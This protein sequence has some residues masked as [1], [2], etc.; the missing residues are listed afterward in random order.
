MKLLRTITL[1][2]AS[3]LITSSTLATSYTWNGTT[4]SAWGIN[5][6]W[7]PNG[8][9]GASDNV[10]IVSSSNDPVYDG[11][12]GVYNLTVTSGTLDLDG[13]TL[14]VS[15]AGTF[16]GGTVTNGTILASSATSFLFEGTLMDC[17]VKGI[18]SGLRMENTVFNDSLVLEKNGSANNSSDGL[19]EFMGP[20]ILLNSG[21]GYL[22]MGAA[23]P[24]TFNS[25]VHLTSANSYISIAQNVG[26]TLFGDNV[27]VKCKTG[28]GV[29][30]GSSATSGITLASGVT[31]TPDT[32]STGL[33]RLWGIGQDDATAQSISLTGDAEL[34]L[35]Y[36]N[37]TGAITASAPTVGLRENIFNGI[38]NFSK[39]GS[40]H[41]G[42][43]GGN[44]F[45]EEAL[46]TNDGSGEFRFQTNAPDTFYD[47]T[48]FTANS[49]RIRLGYGVFSD[50][51]LFADTL[52]FNT[53]AN[54]ANNISRRS[55]TRLEGHVILSRTDGTIDFGIDNG[56]TVLANGSQVI[57][58]SIY[59][60][61]LDIKHVLQ[62]GNTSQAI[63]LA[64]GGI[65]DIDSCRFNGNVVFE[66][67]RITL[68][69]TEF[70]GDAYLEKNSSSNDLAEGG[71][72]FGGTTT[73][74]NSGSGDLTLAN[75][76]GDD[77]NSDVTFVQSS[78]GRIYPGY[79]STSTF[80]GNI[81]ANGI[82]TDLQFG[83]GG[84]TSL[85]VFDGTGV[86]VLSGQATELTFTKLETNKPGGHTT[87]DMVLGISDTLFLTDGTFEVEDGFKAV[88]LKDD[89]V[90][91]GGSD[92]SYVDGIAAKIGDDA[93]VFPVGTDGHIRPIEMSAPAAVVDTF[94]ADYINENPDN[95]YS[96]ASKD[97]SLNRISTN[98][99]WLLDRVSGSSTVNV[100]LNWS[101]MSCEFDTLDNLRITAWNGSQWKDLGNGGTTGT[102]ASGTIVTNGVSTVYGAYTLATVDTFRC[103][104][105][106]ADAGP[107]TFLYYT[108]NIYI[109]A[110]DN[111][112]LT[113]LWTPSDG[114]SDDEISNPLCSADTTTVYTLSTTNS[115]GCVANDQVNVI[116]SYGE[117]WENLLSSMTANYYDV[118]KMAEA[119]AAKYPDVIEDENEEGEGSGWNYFNRWKTYWRSRV[120]DGTAGNSGSFYNSV[121]AMQGIFNEDLCTGTNPS[122][123]EEVGDLAHDF[124]LQN[125]QRV[126]I[127]MHVYDDPDD[128]ENTFY[129]GTRSSG[130]WRT[131][132][133]GAN[134]EC[135]TETAM[136]PSFGVL[137]IEIIPG[138]PRKIYVATGTAFHRISQ[139]IG[140]IMSDDE[141]STWE[142]TALTF[143]PSSNPYFPSEAFFTNIEFNPN[144]S[145]LM[146]A[147]GSDKIFR[148]TDGFAT[149]ANTSEVLDVTDDF[150][151]NYIGTSEEAGGLFW[152]LETGYCPGSPC[153]VYA[154]TRTKS[155][156]AY[157]GPFLLRSSDFGATWTELT[158]F[159]DSNGQPV[160]A[161][162]NIEVA[163][164]PTNPN[165]VFCVIRAGLRIYLFK[166][167]D[168]GTTWFEPRPGLNLFSSDGGAGFYR[169]ELLV[170]KLS[171][172]ILYFSGHHTRKIDLTS[173]NPVV[174]FYS[175]HIDIRSLCRVDNS[176]SSDDILIGCDG[177]VSRVTGS[178]TSST[179]SVSNIN[180]EGFNISEFMGIQNLENVGTNGSETLD[181]YFVGGGKWDNGY[182][183]MREGEWEHTI[184]GDGLNCIQDQENPQFGLGAT[185]V[186]LRL[187]W[188]NSAF[189][190]SSQFSWPNF[191]NPQWEATGDG[192]AYTGLSGGVYKID[193]EQTDG[194]QAGDFVSLNTGVA[195]LSNMTIYALHVVDDQN[196]IAA[197]DVYSPE[198]PNTVE[199]EYCRNLWQTRDGGTSWDEIY[200]D[201]PSGADWLPIEAI[202]TPPNNPN[203]MWISF[204]G[205]R[206]TGF[207]ETDG[208]FRVVKGEYIDDEWVWEDYSDGL[209][210]VPVHDIIYQKGT[211]D[212]L[213]AATEIGVF[214]RDATMEEWKCYSNNLPTCMVTDLEINYCTQE[215]RAGTYGRGLRA[216][217][218]AWTS[219]VDQVISQNETWDRFVGLYGD[220]IIESGV[221]L[222]ITSRVN[223]P[224]GHKIVVEE[225]A[226]LIL[227]GGHLTNTCGEM[228]DGI[229]V[230]GVPGDDQG[231]YMS[232][233]QGMVEMKNGA[234][235]ENAHTGI[236]VATGEGETHKTGGIVDAENSSFR[237][238]RKDVA[239]MAYD[240][241][242]N[243][244]SRFRNCTFINDSPLNAPEYN[245][246]GTNG[247]VSIWGVRGVDFQSCEFVCN[248]DDDDWD[249]DKAYHNWD[250]DGI[251]YNF[252]VDKRG[253]GMGCVD[254]KVL[255]GTTN[256]TNPP[257]A[258]SGC[259]FIGLTIGTAHVST[260]VG[261]GLPNLI[262]N[263]LFSNNQ[264]SVLIEGG[265]GDR[266]IDCDFE[267]P[268]HH[269]WALP[270][271]PHPVGVHLWNSAGFDVKDNDFYAYDGEELAPYSWGTVVRVD[272][273]IY[274]LGI[275]LVGGKIRYNDFD[276]IWS[277]S[278]TE[279]VNISL[280]MSCNNYL[281][282]NEYDWL[283]QP[284]PSTAY[285]HLGNQGT[286]CDPSNQVRAGNSFE[287]NT[288]TNIWS[289]DDNSWIYFSSDQAGY[290]PSIN[291]NNDYVITCTTGD[292][293]SHSCPGPNVTQTPN[294]VRSL[295]IDAENEWN[296][297][298]AEH[299]VV[300][301]DLDSGKTAT[302]LDRLSSAMYS[303]SL[304]T[305]SL[306]YFSPLSDTVLKDV[307]SRDPAFSYAQFQDIVLQNSPVSEPVWQEM[308]DLLDTVKVSAY[309]DTIT[310]AQTSDSIRT[311]KLIEREID[312][313]RGTWN[314]AAN[315]IM[316]MYSDPD[317][318]GKLISYM[319][320]TIDTKN[321]R[322]LLPGTYLQLDSVTEAR[323][324]MDSLWVVLENEDDTAMYN[325]LD[326]RV[327][328]AENSDTWF[329]MDGT[330]TET[331][332]DLANSDYP[333]R[334]FAQAVLTLIHDSV[335]HREPDIFEEP[336]ARI[337]HFG[338]E[339]NDDVKKLVKDIN[340]YP[341]PFQNSFNITYQL[342][343]EAAELQIE[344]FDLLGRTVLTEKIY[345]TS[346][347][348]KLIELGDC[349]GVYIVRIRSGDK[350]LYQAKLI[351]QQR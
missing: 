217:P 78:T 303:N 177:G 33:L 132:D 19:N 258:N 162:E 117:G 203:K 188:T 26:G 12:A 114:L 93:F 84:S 210:Y 226:K 249:S 89:A 80:A 240:G 269:A 157:C 110:E 174:A 123:W 225:G 136:L 6:N 14:A 248:L 317:S 173:P 17:K 49:H 95:Y 11:V 103:V 194:F 3:I 130:L 144:N 38:A 139:G 111:P 331:I 85:S 202:T 236:M 294:Q 171:D 279:G 15:N 237:N 129:A 178:T 216:S 21:T 59:A 199:S 50:T 120:D 306:V 209:S 141:G 118:L 271:W 206:S 314:N 309:V 151:C 159:Y 313:A 9:P 214:Y 292:D 307:V 197:K 150:N 86:Q 138:S 13:Y 155:G 198:D 328:L 154:T 91:I 255:I 207:N 327:S 267:L 321:M 284:V 182:H 238:N 295:Q 101:D 44:I 212:G 195:G 54:V 289:F 305:D 186:W 201:M 145:S 230:W 298:L 167:T 146:L 66:S 143:N 37:L 272:N 135:I 274:N 223:I 270:V 290:I 263:S 92:T 27:E 262:H 332:I 235:I 300:T 333:V 275:S 335:Y 282:N 169:F 100:T 245:G 280:Q 318:I 229:Q 276:Y 60:A 296:T 126:G 119:Y 246:D 47:K 32:F 16:S 24:D 69:Y 285:S 337:G 81:T 232:T 2:L 52:V 22:R 72:I 148:S 268:D 242:N 222:T 23:E 322:I 99:A 40:T 28:D 106:V 87:V 176:G 338:D 185:A 325:L 297:L 51:T 181:P 340:I 65:L 168:Y 45:N 220:L 57:I 30:L 61:R 43:Y 102:T 147:T 163:V 302:L 107:D 179:G 156:T 105:C 349:Q 63:E 316:Y 283:I 287:D 10:T 345:N 90:Y 76:N 244:L 256:Q 193:M 62:E 4:S 250:S 149:V 165:V 183:F 75:A 172:D 204:S 228:W 5:T 336:G 310:W 187:H 7:T 18:T 330:E 200:C 257:P 288:N 74:I 31:I 109:G 339:G 121:I 77:F 166:S 347:G 53:N 97:G 315:D 247:H 278:Q 34:S 108:N 291:S 205:F 96:I 164:S 20:V 299:V 286:G 25:T 329:D 190:S 8:V 213:Y 261:S 301:S 41:D 221:T 153:Y 94:F 191:F 133:A 239:F 241:D 127:V 134:W 88:L 82:I 128:P 254:A 140:I 42:N 83:N 233:T 343:E 308:Q 112:D 175:S 116:V 211:N 265:Y 334:V 281:E 273:S 180:G 39:T 266:I 341:N 79:N 208:A 342:E 227:D 70:N 184:T 252:D 98:E 260:A 259:H 323:E 46:F 58:D 1:F 350:T 115:N 29:Y 113:Y 196:I 122:D 251:D 215:L 326:V 312:I 68:G 104:P 346:G 351:C 35:Q 324:A 311:L 304:L 264:Q 224:E 124:R 56:R 142:E 73:I 125:N 344:V 160:V 158:G 192:Y 218:L 253:I 243:S 152:D 320:D 234:I 293:Q 137:D 71:N 64:S 55:H 348:T 48:T 67:P 219:T 189:N 170:S 161:T 319:K 277:A 231:T 36:S 131:E